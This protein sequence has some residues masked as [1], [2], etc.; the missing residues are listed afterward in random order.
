MMT[1]VPPDEATTSSVLRTSILSDTSHFPTHDSLAGKKMPQCMICM[2]ES[3][4]W[5]VH[6][7]KA[8]GHNYA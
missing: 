5:N 1:F 4:L 3:V 2:E 7:G 6:K 8:N